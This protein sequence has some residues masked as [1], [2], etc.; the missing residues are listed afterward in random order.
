[1]QEGIKAE[2]SSIARNYVAWR[3]VPSSDISGPGGTFAWNPPSLAPPVPVPHAT[4]LVG[5][6][7]VSTQTSPPPMG[8][9]PSLVTF[10][11][12][13]SIPSS[14]FIY[15]RAYISLINWFIYL[16]IIFSLDCNIHGAPGRSSR[17]SHVMRS[18]FA[19]FATSHSFSFLIFFSS[20]HILRQAGRRYKKMVH[21]GGGGGLWRRGGELVHLGSRFLK[22]SQ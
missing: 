21:G 17:L 16:F 22:Y 9:P 15:F 3:E 20:H 19:F 2:D 6:L 14:C 1:M 11:R 18:Y 10:F 13:A 4:H 12:M 5:L 8:M 7:Q